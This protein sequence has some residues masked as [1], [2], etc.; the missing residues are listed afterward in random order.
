[1]WPLAVEVFTSCVPRLHT[2][3]S[4]N[5]VTW[6]P[7]H[8]FAHAPHAYM[9]KRW[10][11]QL[12]GNEHGSSAINDVYLKLEAGSL[13][14][15]RA[16]CANAVTVADQPCVTVVAAKSAELGDMAD[17]RNDHASRR[18]QASILRG[19]SASH[20]QS[21]TLVSRSSAST[22]TTAPMN[23]APSVTSNIGRQILQVRVSK[24]QRADVNRE[25]PISPW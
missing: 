25:R 16:A 12:S 21:T 15:H 1:M 23:K 10:D 4:I 6:I 8:T 7:N 17:E 3:P 20:Q 22:T 24:D 5:I 11:G 18:E 2:L 19:A 14:G 13:G 9:S